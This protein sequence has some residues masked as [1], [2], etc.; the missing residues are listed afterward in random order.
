MALVIIPLQDTA[1]GTVD[2]YLLAEPDLNR[3][4]AESATEAQKLALK[5][6]NGANAQE[7]KLVGIDDRIRTG[8]VITDID[9][10][11]N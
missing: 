1:D 10:V 4:T 11:L 9:E 2:M 5:M 6:L 7:Q 8:G 3:V